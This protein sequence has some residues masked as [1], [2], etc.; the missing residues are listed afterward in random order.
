MANRILVIASDEALA[1]ATSEQLTARGHVVNTTADGS[2]G[3]QRARA[4]P[5]ALGVVQVELE[6]GQNGYLVCGKWKKD[7]A[8]S[9]VPVVI[10]GNREG[11][12][13][14]QKLKTRADGY[15]AQPVDVAELVAVVERLLQGAPAAPPKAAP[16]APAAPGDATG[17][18]GLWGWLRG[19]LGF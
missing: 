15:V 5:P 19:L 13:S 1:R 14:H 2:E 18:R 11:F 12:A 4:S 3:F 10:V 7:E 9:R 8:L 17:R 6:N 16:V